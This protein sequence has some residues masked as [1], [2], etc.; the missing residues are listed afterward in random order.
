MKNTLSIRKPA[1]GKEDML[2]RMVRMEARLQEGFK[3][4][5]VPLEVFADHAADFDAY[6]DATPNELRKEIATRL[7]RTETKLVKGFD[8]LGANVVGQKPAVIVDNVE[9]TIT[10]SSV[11]ATIGDLLK[12]TAVYPNTRFDVVHNNQVI[13]VFL[14]R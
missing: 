3:Q 4:L 6:A 11:N 5:G 12:A 2:R 13:C 7:K 1:D 8:S 10:V 9:G 14:T